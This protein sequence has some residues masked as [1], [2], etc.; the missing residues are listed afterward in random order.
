MIN[1]YFKI[2]ISSRQRPGRHKTANFIWIPMIPTKRCKKRK[3]K[4]H[5]AIIITS[6]KCKVGC[7]FSKWSKGW[8]V[9]VSVQTLM[10]DIMLI[11][12]TW[13]C[14]HLSASS[15]A[16]PGISPHALHEF[17]EYAFS[18]S[19]SDNE[20]LCRPCLKIITIWDTGKQIKTYYCIGEC[21]HKKYNTKYNTIYVA[22]I[23]CLYHFDW[24]IQTNVPVFFKKQQRSSLKPQWTSLTPTWWLSPLPDNQK[25][26]YGDLRPNP[27]CVRSWC[28]CVFPFTFNP[29]FQRQA[30]AWTVIVR[31][32]QAWTWGDYL[33]YSSCVTVRCLP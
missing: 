14:L 3:T 6:A 1:S 26:A 24:I 33:C 28:V 18:S 32:Q 7:W 20:G 22:Y 30:K 15:S 21:H 29:T 9:C 11:T 10:V 17:L 12:V 19:E 31:C 13:V 2:A 27:S 8:R 23:I 25:K 4:H 16:S 5:Q